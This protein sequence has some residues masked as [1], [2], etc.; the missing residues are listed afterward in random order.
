MDLTGTSV[1]DN[2]ISQLA[3]FPPCQGGQGGSWPV[4]PIPGW[5]IRSVIDQGFPLSPPLKKGKVNYR[6]GF[7]A[8]A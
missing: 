1:R 6:K 3:N 2:D 7:E 5:L 4:E 8:L